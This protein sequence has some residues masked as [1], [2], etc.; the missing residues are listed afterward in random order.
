MKEALHGLQRRPELN[1][2][3]VEVEVLNSQLH[4]HPTSIS[5]K[6]KVFEHLVQQAG[7]GEGGQVAVKVL[8]S[9][10][11]LSVKHENILLDTVVEMMERVMLD[12]R[13][14][15]E[16][17]D[18]MHDR[19][20]KARSLRDNG[21][22]AKAESALLT[23][24]AEMEEVCGTHS[25]HLS[26]FLKSL[27]IL[28]VTQE[29]EP[30]AEVAL[31]RMD[32]LRNC[33]SPEVTLISDL[34]WLIP[35]QLAVEHYTDANENAKRLASLEGPSPMLLEWHFQSVGRAN[36]DDDAATAEEVEHAE[37]EEVITSRVIHDDA[38]SVAVQQNASCA[39]TVSPET[40]SVFSEPLR[41]A[42]LDPAL[43]YYF[44]IDD[45]CSSSR[46][47]ERASLLPRNAWHFDLHFHL[48]MGATH[49]PR[50]FRHF[51]RSAH[52]LRCGDTRCAMLHE[53]RP[54]F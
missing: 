8:A 51:G 25:H 11:I 33:R 6:F 29:R 16:W 49:C 31:A 54:R 19:G 35:A 4:L 7:K 10:Q 43:T 53:D 15:Q 50:F 12:V 34:R 13:K 44:S 41:E 24:L 18:N 1:G 38:L 23:L 40:P 46:L 39:S 37:V 32:R 42:I 22:F 26:D 27:G 2:Q 14:F 48:C 52:Q 47:I 5:Y 20:E 21:Q 45:V 9:G 36:V 28:Y 3:R 17:Q 30:E